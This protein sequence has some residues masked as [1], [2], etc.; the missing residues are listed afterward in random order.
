[1]KYPKLKG[2]IIEMFGSQQKFA[3]AV[4][5]SE[6][7]ISKKLTGQCGISQDDVY[8]WSNALQLNPSEIAI[9]FFPQMFNE[10]KE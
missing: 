9:Y 1:M 2:K 8:E 10:T 5:Q 6:H 3:K 7:M 4:N